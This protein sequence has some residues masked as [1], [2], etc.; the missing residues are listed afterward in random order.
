MPPCDEGNGL[1]G[2]GGVGGCCSAAPG[3]A[4]P[5][6]KPQWGQYTALGGTGPWQPGHIRAVQ[7]TQNRLF[8]SISWP[9]LGHLII[10]G[11]ILLFLDCFGA[12]T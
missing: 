2:G 8:E 5:T 6:E 11:T 9:Q 10:P 3:I 7:C 4:G 12:P 1:G